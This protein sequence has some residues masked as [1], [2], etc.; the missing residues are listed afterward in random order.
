[1]GKITQWNL[2]P[3]PPPRPKRRKHNYGD[4]DEN[5][6][7]WGCCI[8]YCSDTLLCMTR[9]SCTLWQAVWYRKLN[10]WCI[11]SALMIYGI[12][13]FYLSSFDTGPLAPFFRGYLNDLVCPLFFLGFCQ[14]FLIWVGHELRSYWPCLLLTMAAGLIWEYG[15]PLINPRSVSDP[16]D[17]LCYLLGCTLYYTLLR[18]SAQRDNFCQQA[19]ERTE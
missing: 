7:C 1:M 6:Y 12:N 13:H 19:L 3:L 9:S 2:S 5:S 16:L 15:A 8:G 4:L 17:L 14:I 18:R 10:L 11:C